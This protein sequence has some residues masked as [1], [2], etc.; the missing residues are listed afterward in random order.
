MIHNKPTTK[1]NLGH[2]IWN[3]YWSNQTENVK[4]GRNTARDT[5]TLA[6]SSFYQNN[7]NELPP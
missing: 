2:K 1:V 3:D 7:G 6:K 4:M 5:K